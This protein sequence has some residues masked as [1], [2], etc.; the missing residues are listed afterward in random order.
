MVPAPPGAVGAHHLAAR[1]PTGDPLVA[2]MVGQ[3]A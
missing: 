1:D 2:G 3:G